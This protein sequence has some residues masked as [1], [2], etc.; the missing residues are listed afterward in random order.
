M[1]IIVGFNETKIL[2]DSKE[3]NRVLFEKLNLT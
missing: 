2:K 1:E 3:R